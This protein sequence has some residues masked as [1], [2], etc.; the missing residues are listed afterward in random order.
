M[1]Y[2]PL[3]YNKNIQIFSAS[4]VYKINVQINYYIIIGGLRALVS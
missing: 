3:K 2:L 4:V 1:F